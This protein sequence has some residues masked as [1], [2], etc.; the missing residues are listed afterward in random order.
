V[1]GNP[2]H[3]TGELFK[4]MAGVDLLHV[5]YRG[6]PPA[7]TDLVGGRVQVTHDVVRTAGGIA[8]RPMRHRGIAAWRSPIGDVALVA[9]ID[10]MIGQ[11]AVAPIGFLCT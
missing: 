8:L 9:S 3:V 2:I 4:V 1:T 5:P 7:L 6:S 11:P 10:Q